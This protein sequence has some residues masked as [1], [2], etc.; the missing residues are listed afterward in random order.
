[1]RSGYLAKSIKWLAMV[2]APSFSH[3]KGSEG[4]A[5]ALGSGADQVR[6]TYKEDQVVC[7]GIKILVKYLKVVCNN[8][9]CFWRG[10]S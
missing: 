6:I 4:H 10:Y 1:M 9:H 8:L 5:P 7:H 2:L 3:L